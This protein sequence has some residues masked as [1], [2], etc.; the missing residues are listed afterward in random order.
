M[1]GVVSIQIGGGVL[2]EVGTWGG[3]FCAQD[4]GGLAITV[5]YEYQIDQF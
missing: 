5:V 1:R 3:A 4:E 2:I